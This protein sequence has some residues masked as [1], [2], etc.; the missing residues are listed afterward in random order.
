MLTKTDKD[1]I[2]RAIKKGVEQAIRDL[3]TL[4]QVGGY[5]GATEYKDD[6][7]ESE[8]VEFRSRRRMGFTLPVV[9]DAQ[10]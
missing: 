3:P 8:Y 2:R 10:K 5:D 4:E 6:L 1:W 7:D 9:S